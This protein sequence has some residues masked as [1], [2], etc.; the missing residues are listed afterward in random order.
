M[1]LRRG[2]GSFLCC[3]LLTGWQGWGCTDGVTAQSYSR[4]MAAALLLTLSNLFFIPPIVVAL[5]R[6]YHVEAAIYFFTMFFSSVC[7]YVTILLS[8]CLSM[9]P[10]YACIHNNCVFCSFITRVTSPVWLWCVSWTTTPSSSVISW[11]P[12]CLYGWPL[13]AWHGFRSQ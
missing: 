7:F 6:G 5:H 10:E 2:I 8:I 13:C 12:S 11:V 3:L 4:Q 9:V 1:V